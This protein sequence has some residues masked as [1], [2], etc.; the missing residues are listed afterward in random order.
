[1]ELGRAGKRAPRRQTPGAGRP[2]L[3][4]TTAMFVG[5]NGRKREPS[6]GMGVPTYYVFSRYFGQV[7]PV[8]EEERLV[9]T[10]RPGREK[11]GTPAAK[12][13]RGEDGISISR[14]KGNLDVGHNY[15]GVTISSWRRYRSIA[16]VR[17]DALPACPFAVAWLLFSHGWLSPRT[18]SRKLHNEF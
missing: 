16:H 5:R 10:G 8:A 13:W 3:G 15:D 18:R 12:C 14:R 2:R 9:V 7:R 17:Q 6:Q 4:T 11:K 1:M